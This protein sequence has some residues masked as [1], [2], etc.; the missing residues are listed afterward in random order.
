MYQIE[1]GIPVFKAGSKS[2]FYPLASMS[3][4]DSFTIPFDEYQGLRAAIS[5]FRARGFASRRFR[6]GQYQDGNRLRFRVWRMDDWSEPQ[7]I[8]TTR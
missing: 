3:V 6:A 1:Q 7:R 2:S 4:G 5:R 8:R